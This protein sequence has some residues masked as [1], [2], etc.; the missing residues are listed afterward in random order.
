MTNRVA[1][2]FAE[3]VASKGEAFLSLFVKAQP[4]IFAYVLTLLPHR[5]DAEDVM[6][7]ASL[8]LWNNFDEADPPDDFAAWGCRVAYYRIKEHRRAGQRRGVA[9]SDDVLERLVRTMTDERAALLANEQGEALSQCIDKLPRRDRELLAERFRDR[10][11]TAS[12]AEQVG[13][14][15]D[16]VYKAMARIRRAL[17]ECVGRTL[18]AEGRR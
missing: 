1:T 10:A 11:T 3:E 14:S 5:A 15:V 2:L 13:R 18:A 12:T 4:R 6:Q 16:A 9:F 8:F 17:H 7:E